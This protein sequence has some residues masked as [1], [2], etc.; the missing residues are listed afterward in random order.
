MPTLDDITILQTN[1]K[2]AIN[3]PVAVVDKSS[4]GSSRVEQFPLGLIAQGFT[5]AW[6]INYNH[7]NFTGSG[8]S[9]TQVD[10]ILHT[11]TATERL[12][13]V[14]CIVTEAFTSADTL[15]GLAINVGEGT[16]SIGSLVDGVQGITL[17]DNET[18]TGSGLSGTLADPAEDNPTDGTLLV[19]TDLSGGATADD[20]TAGQ[21]VVLADI[22]DL[23]DY[24]D[25]V[26]RDHLL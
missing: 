19:R 4:S 14:K 20:M 12:T 1:N 23:S 16:G 10:F 18:N 21:F 6:C 24:K 22:Y 26:V 13:K 2:V 15:S 11:F 9:A 17:N 8:G 5:H 7:T 3:D 25:C